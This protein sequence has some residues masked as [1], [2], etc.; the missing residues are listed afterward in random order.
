MVKKE[1]LFNVFNSESK[2]VEEFVQANASKYSQSQCAIAI[3][4]IFSGIYKYLQFKSTTSE[5]FQRHINIDS[6]YKYL[7]TDCLKASDHALKCYYDPT[8]E[9]NNIKPYLKY[10]KKLNEYANPDASDPDIGLTAD[11]RAALGEFCDVLS[12]SALEWLNW[13]WDLCPLLLRTEKTDQISPRKIMSRGVVSDE[14]YDL[15]ISFEKNSF[16][17]QGW[18]AIE[19][20]ELT[21]GN[22]FYWISDDVLHVKIHGNYDELDLSKIV[23]SSGKTLPTYTYV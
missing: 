21:S 8:D 7:T 2:R 9:Q 4:R 13:R 14:D 20:L 18:K 19:N 10:L 6:G 17:S 16:M 22:E 23:V 5:T 3:E 1:H 11:E 12:K 15:Y